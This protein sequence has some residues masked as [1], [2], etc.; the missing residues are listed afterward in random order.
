MENVSTTSV[1]SGTT[2]RSHDITPSP[3]T[4]P[5]HKPKKE[6]TTNILP[7]SYFGKVRYM[8]KVYDTSFYVLS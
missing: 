7:P 4:S 3:V 2:P 8:V 1:H 5:S 6:Q